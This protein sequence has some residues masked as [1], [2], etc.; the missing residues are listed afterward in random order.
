MKMTELEPKSFYKFFDRICAVPHGSGNE[1]ALSDYV[2]EFAL[3]KGLKAVQD[4]AFNVIIS[5]PG[6]KNYENAPTVILQGHLDMVCE[7][8]NST[9]HDFLREGIKTVVDGD[10]VRAAGTTLGGDN[11]VA[12]AYAM[13]LLDSDD[14]PH[15]PLTVILTT[16]EETGMLGASALAPEHV[17]GE[18]L[19]N[20][21]S[22]TEGEFTVS[23]AGGVRATVTLGVQK[24]ALP[25]GLA[26]YAL[27]VSGLKGGHSG[28]DIDKERG[29]ANRVLGR[30]LSAL[31]EKFGIYLT[32]IN[33]GEKENAIPREAEAVLCAPSEKSGEIKDFIECLAG[34]LKREYKVSDPEIQITFSSLPEDSPKTAFS[35][36][37]TKKIITVVQLI[38][39]GIQNL[40]TGLPGVETSANLGVVRTCGDAVAFSSAIRSSMASRKKRVLDQ[41]RNIA[42]I[43]GASFSSFGDYPSWEFDP[44]S[45]LRGICAEVF[46]GMYAGREPELLSIHAG[47]EC[48]VI[49]E[50]TNGLDI[51]SFGPD[52]FDAHTPE[53]RVSISSIK[54]TWEFLKEVL[55]KLNK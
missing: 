42:E 37:T 51:I 9:E 12:V 36:E 6:T 54:R 49:S 28:L 8:N 24:E 45:K 35:K 2:Y 44:D 32:S 50:K 41:V 30:L 29:N 38:P 13:M 5:K 17:T 22:F 25:P 34:V 48:G 31:D 55:A 53:E 26:A 52:L 4:E 23:C 3:S 40:N 11:G 14:I 33:G 10:F 1:K 19:I 47:I 27:S 46:K 7:K 43:T 20:L 15:P 39:N 18:R 21:D 16:G